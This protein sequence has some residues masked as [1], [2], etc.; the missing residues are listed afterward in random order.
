MM[1]VDMIVWI[2]ALPGLMLMIVSGVT[3]WGLLLWWSW[4]KLFRRKKGDKW[5]TRTQT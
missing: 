5:E 3:V 1:N 2:A 4:T